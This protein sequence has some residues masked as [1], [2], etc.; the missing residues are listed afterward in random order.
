MS[1]HLHR[2]CAII[3]WNFSHFFFSFFHANETLLTISEQKVSKSFLFYFCARHFI[4][5][6]VSDKIS[7]NL[8]CVLRFV[9]VIK[10]FLFHFLFT[11]TLD[12]FL[13]LWAIYI[14][15]IVY[16]CRKT[17][18]IER[19]VRSSYQKKSFSTTFS[20]FIA[21][22]TH[23]KCQPQKTFIQISRAIMWLVVGLNKLTQCWLNMN[24]FFFYRVL[25]VAGLGSGSSSQL[26]FDCIQTSALYGF[27]SSSFQVLDLDQFVWLLRQTNKIIKII[28][29]KMLKQLS[30]LNNYIQHLILFH[31]RV[32]TISTGYDCRVPVRCVMCV[33]VFECGICN[34]FKI[35]AQN[36]GRMCDRM[37]FP[38]RAW[39]KRRYFI[40][41]ANVFNH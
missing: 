16:I 17:V 12:L 7:V 29:K 5:L 26:Y 10:W 25:Y 24:V 4:T 19:I 6:S 38:K 23:I 40:S 30:L 27:M 32:F 21:F 34:K 1:N 15:A 31:V 18:R 3:K 37:L 28:K 39:A 41:E 22:I 9:F 14:A 11:P 13:F 20:P 36:I 33:C 2:N 8:F 35:L